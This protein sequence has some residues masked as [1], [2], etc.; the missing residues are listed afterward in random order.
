MTEFKDLGH[1]A[2]KAL[3]WDD[4]IIGFDMHPSVVDGVGAVRVTKG[5]DAEG[6]P[7]EFVEVWDGS[8]HA[9]ELLG[10]AGVR[11]SKDEHTTTSVLYH[12]RWQLVF[13]PSSV[14]LSATAAPAPSSW[15]ED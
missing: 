13:A 6:N 1:A 7:A 5:R 4:E 3:H 9:G 12:A 14:R 11:P 15:G 8:I 10:S 2:P